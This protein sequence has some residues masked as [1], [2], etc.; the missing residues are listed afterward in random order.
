VVYPPKSRR[1]SLQESGISQ[2]TTVGVACLHDRL[3]PISRFEQ[4][5]RVC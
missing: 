4:I 5:L 3:N 2:A 1:E